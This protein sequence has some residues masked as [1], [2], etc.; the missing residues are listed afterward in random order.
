MTF[1]AVEAMRAV[2]PPDWLWLPIRRS[3]KLRRERNVRSDGVLLALSSERGIEARSDDGGRQQPA[4]TTISDYWLVQP[5][6]VVFNPMWAIGGGVAASRIAGAVSPAYRVYSPGPLVLPRFLHDYLRSAGVIAQYGLV[7]RGLTTFDRSVTRY[8]FEMMPVPVPCCALQRAIADFLD[9]ETA[10]IADLIA[11]KRRQSDLLKARLETMIRH[12]LVNL[13]S[14]ILPLKRRWRVVDCKHRTPHYIE[15]GYPVVSPG[16]ATPGRLNLARCHR[17]V[18]DRDFLDLTEPPRRPRRGDIIYSRNASIGIASFVDTDQPFCMG[19]DV[20][21]ITSHDQ[22]QQYLA[23]VLNT[24]GLDQLDE[25]KIGSTFSR[26]NVSQIMDL[27]IPWVQPSEQRSLA[28]EFDSASSII[29][30]VRLALD[31]QMTVLRERHAALISA[32]VTGQ[33]DIPRASAA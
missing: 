28:A 33:L 31:D 14:A 16:D 13:D 25:A 11:K 18:S 26:I 8:D 23:F 10:R 12:R 21:L 5:G 17:F 29:D 22:N 2:S 7:T 3:M 32:A 1:L 24:L 27:Q 9:A 20:C 30:R 6:D 4:E 19:Q 15:D